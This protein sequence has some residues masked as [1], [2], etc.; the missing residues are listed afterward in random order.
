MVVLVDDWKLKTIIGH[1]SP[2]FFVACAPQNDI[3]ENLIA[4]AHPQ[5]GLARIRPVDELL[6]DRPY[7]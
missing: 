4:L 7:L 3:I 1:P 2:G 6:G 5:D